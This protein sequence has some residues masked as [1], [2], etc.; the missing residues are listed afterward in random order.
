MGNFRKRLKKIM[1]SSNGIGWGYYDGLCDEYYGSF[2]VD[3]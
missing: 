1:L 2:K 3:E